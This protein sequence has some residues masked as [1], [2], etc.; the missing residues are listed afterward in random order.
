MSI[1]VI[2]QW[3][4]WH[5]NASLLQSYMDSE[6]MAIMSQYMPLDNNDHRNEIQQLRQDSTA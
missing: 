3:D 2:S 5:I 4:P 1:F 6:V